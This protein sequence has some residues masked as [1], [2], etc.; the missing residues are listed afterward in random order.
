MIHTYIT[1]TTCV[2]QNQYYAFDLHF[3]YK[4]YEFDSAVCFWCYASNTSCLLLIHTQ[5]WETSCLTCGHKYIQHHK[6]HTNSYFAIVREWILWGISTKILLA[7]AFVIMI[8]RAIARKEFLWIYHC[9][10]DR[11]KHLGAITASSFWTDLFIHIYLLVGVY[12]C[13]C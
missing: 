10:C 8:A 5:Q 2:K 6:I 11:N 13:L 1:I 12:L 3:L 4:Y 7:I 9:N